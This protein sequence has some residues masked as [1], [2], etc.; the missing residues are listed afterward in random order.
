MPGFITI[1]IRHIQYCPANHYHI[2]IPIRRRRGS[3]EGRKALMAGAPCGSE[4]CSISGSVAIRST[5]EEKWRNWSGRAASVCD[6][7]RMPTAAALSAAND[8]IGY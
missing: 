3:D 1:S 4:C 2:I 5:A 8:I 6:S 7:A